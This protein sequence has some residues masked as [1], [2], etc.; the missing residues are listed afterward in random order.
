MNKQEQL[1]RAGQ[2]RLRRDIETTLHMALWMKAYNHDYQ[3]RHQQTS[4]TDSTAGDIAPNGTDGHT[5]LDHRSR[6]GE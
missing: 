2:L 4:D 6:A 1:K 3:Q 5:L